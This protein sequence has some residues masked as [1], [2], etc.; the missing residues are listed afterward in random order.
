MRRTNSCGKSSSVTVLIKAS[1]TPQPHFY[2]LSAFR[3]FSVE[4]AASRPLTGFGKT[5]CGQCESILFGSCFD[6]CVF[7]FYLHF[8]IQ[9]VFCSGQ[10]KSVRIDTRDF[11]N[12]DCFFI[13]FLTEKCC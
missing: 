10:D 4:E 13:F 1:K 11:S 7:M 8:Q 12:L 5:K 2:P 6:P 3:S 9:C